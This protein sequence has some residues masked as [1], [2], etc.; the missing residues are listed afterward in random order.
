MPNVFGSATSAKGTWGTGIAYGNNIFAVNAQRNGTHRTT[1]SGDSWTTKEFVNAD[2]PH[3]RSMLFIPYQGGRFISFGDGGRFTFSNDGGV[4][5]TDSTTSCPH[6]GSF[7]WGVDTLIAK[8]NEGICSSR[9]GAKTW[10]ITTRF[11]GSGGIVWTGADFYISQ[12]YTKT[13]HRS[14][15]GIAWRNETIGVGGDAGWPEVLSASDTGTLV[16]ANGNGDSFFRSTDSG[17]S[18]S[19][20]S[21]PTGTSITAVTFGHGAASPEC[22]APR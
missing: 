2:L 18:W 22:P 10:T 4:T 17:K 7:A 1:D 16:G 9:D 19:K 11:T 13:A 15:D 5:W 3:R 12:A 20:V 21:A 6:L 14:S 8:N